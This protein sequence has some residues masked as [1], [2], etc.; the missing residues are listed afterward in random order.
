M[1]RPFSSGMR[2]AP[3]LVG[4]DGPKSG[5]GKGAGLGLNRRF[6]AG[7]EAELE[8]VGDLEERLH[9]FLDSH[10]APGYIGWI[11][12]GVGITQV[13]PAARAPA[14]PDLE[15]CLSKVSA[16]VDLS[17]ARRIGTRGG[18]I[19][20]GGRVRPFATRHGARR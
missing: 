11:V 20:V 4:A 16:V 2:T 9:V 5:V 18:S 7:V 12:P 8:G 13:G 15:R 1:G 6:L 19:P 3:V 17:G 14:R 10:L